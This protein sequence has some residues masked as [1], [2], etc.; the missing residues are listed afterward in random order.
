MEPRRWQSLVVILILLA[1]AG[2]LV[3]W[4]APTRAESVRT[5]SSTATAAGDRKTSASTPRA[6]EPERTV[7]SESAPR[8]AEPERA[9]R[10]EPTPRQAPPEPAA[11]APRQPATAPAGSPSIIRP[12]PPTLPPTP[13]PVLPPSA[14]PPPSPT[15]TIHK[16][17]TVALAPRGSGLT[18]AEADPE[19]R[20]TRVRPTPFETVPPAPPPPPPA[21]P[22]IVIGAPGEGPVDGSCEDALVCPLDR[23][24][25]YIAWQLVRFVGVRYWEV[26]YER[27]DGWSWYAL[28]ERLDIP[29]RDFYDAVGIRGWGDGVFFSDTIVRREVQ[30]QVGYRRLPVFS[31]SLPIEVP[32]PMPDVRALDRFDRAILERIA[33]ET[34]WCEDVLALLYASEGSWG[35]VAQRLYLSPYLFEGCFGVR[36]TI[37]GFDYVHY[38]TDEEIVW[39]VQDLEARARP[40]RPAGSRGEL[41]L[42]GV[43]LIAIVVGTGM[44]LGF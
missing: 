9:V 39:A 42:G 29:T 28:L 14:E 22:V 24:D 30:R 19:P 34:L 16:P 21:D 20:E 40:A 35:G 4:A 36:L 7:R 31:C 12:S 32:G 17:A 41:L 5:R 1:L 23:T 43:T 33:A 37:D 27:L 25:D 18:V 15:P 11:P 10:S 3:L 6:A 13:R 26:A 44:A 2:L 8:A 38:P